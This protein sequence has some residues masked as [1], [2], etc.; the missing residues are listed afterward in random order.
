[1][2][3]LVEGTPLEVV[4]KREILIHRHI[5]IKRR[6]FGKITD[7]PLCV[8]R[9]V[10][11]IDTSYGYAAGSGR[12]ISC[13]DIHRRTLTGAVRS[14]KADNFTALHL[15]ADIVNGAERAVILNQVRY[16]N[17]KKRVPFILDYDT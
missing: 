3:L 13:D 7:E 2:L 1:M 8:Q 11:N 17:H 9:V 4:A 10:E 16:F 6:L 5:G 14:E 12:E 15:K